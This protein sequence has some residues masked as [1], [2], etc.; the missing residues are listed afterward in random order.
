M[1]LKKWEIALISAVVVTM[2]WGL[3]GRTPCL[4][5]WGSIY[6][7]LA[8]PNGSVQTVSAMDGETVVLRLRLLEWLEACLRALGIG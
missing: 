8:P 7:E 1:S 4:A 5:W 6:P 3:L 2:L